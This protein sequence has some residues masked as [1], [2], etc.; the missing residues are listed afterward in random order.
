MLP[1]RPSIS[2][3]PTKSPSTTP[4]RDVGLP[5]IHPPIPAPGWGAASPPG[6]LR[7]ALEDLYSYYEENE[8]LLANV[9]R[10]FEAVPV[11]GEVNELVPYL[12]QARQDTRFRL[13]CPG[14][15]S[16]EAVWCD[17]SRDGIHDLA[18]ADSAPGPEEEWRHRVDGSARDGRR[19]LEKAGVRA[20]GRRR[21][22]EY[23]HARGTR[24]H[25]SGATTSASESGLRPHHPYRVGGSPL[26]RAGAVDPAR[27][28]GHVVVHPRL[29]Q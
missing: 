10:D 17:R 11:L 3:F 4:V 1:G 18:I 7:S 19:G 24:P 8:S 13:G 29:P 28:R 6:R 26:L 25:R 27:L 15:S 9:A 2:T 23:G 21:R 16:Q 5:I 20:T 14:C 12:A 22:V